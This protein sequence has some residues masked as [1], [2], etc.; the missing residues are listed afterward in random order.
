MSAPPTRALVAV[1]DEGMA[2]AHRRFMR[3]GVQGAQGASLTTRIE[4]I[5]VQDVSG[6]V[7]PTMMGMEIT[8]A[9]IDAAAQ[10]ADKQGGIDESAY[11]AFGVLD[12][13]VDGYKPLARR[14]SHGTHVLD[15]A[16][17]YE[18]AQAPTNLPLI[19][20]EM[21][22]ASLGDPAGATLAVHAAWGLVYVLWRAQSLR[23][24]PTATLPIV[25]NLS[26]GPHEGPHDGSSLFE[27]FLDAL[28]TFS[29]TIET[30]LMPVFAAG[31]YRQSRVHASFQLLPGQS[32]SLTWRLQPGGQTPSFMEI[33]FP[34][35][36]PAH[37]SLLMPDATT[38]VSVSTVLTPPNVI[39][40]ST[41]PA[42]MQAAMQL[43]SVG[44]SLDCIVISLAPTAQDFWAAA[45]YAL[46]P[47]GPWTVVVALGG[48]PSTTA[49]QVQF[50]AWIKRSDTPPGRRAKGRQSYFDDPQYERFDPMGRPTE[51]DAIGSK[52]YVRRS[53]TLS[54]I[55][56]GCE[57]FVIGGYCR[58]PD[59]T[60]QKPAHYSSEGAPVA[61]PGRAMYPV[62]WAEPI[63]DSPSCSGILAAGTRNGTRVKMSGTSAAAPQAARV[64][65]EAWAGSGKSP[66]PIPPVGST[67][68]P[69]SNKVP[70]TDRPLVSGYGLRRSSP[71]FPHPGEWRRP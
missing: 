23:L 70:S 20:V 52:S 32:Q 6:A 56:T 14:F 33:H 21:P 9:Q 16:S 34:A 51:F 36:T 45:P 1:I 39:V 67:V 2:F 37:V 15:T 38:A 53:N 7:P 68:D 63:E 49:D 8:A 44:T 54:G 40:Q 18:L 66:G 25:A 17:G 24:P 60:E 27:R 42:M 30:P 12:M 58:E 50:D 59:L 64:L 55:A 35:N 57:T 4:Y 71:P 62:N 22:E 47:S 29:R 61:T 31:N 41:I 11:R 19:A 13:T 10:T 3:A 65:A 43:C 5:W 48:A 46:A 26:Y 28:V 69:P